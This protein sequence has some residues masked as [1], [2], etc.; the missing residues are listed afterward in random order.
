MISTELSNTSDWI[1]GWA[2]QGRSIPPR[3]AAN[4]ARMLLDLSSQARQLERLPVDAE[5]LH[6]D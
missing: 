3:E 5:A 6:D 2:A 4:L 1:L